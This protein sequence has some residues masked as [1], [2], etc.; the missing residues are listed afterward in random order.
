[1]NLDKDD[2]DH[3]MSHSKGFWIW[4]VM[5]SLLVGLITFSAIYTLLWFGS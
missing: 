3:I 4:A 2:L 1:M 5:Y